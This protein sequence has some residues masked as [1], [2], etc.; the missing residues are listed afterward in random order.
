MNAKL[1]STIILL[2]TSGLSLGE[3]KVEPKKPAYKVSQLE[4]A[5]QK[6]FIFLKNQKKLLDERLKRQGAQ[7]SQALQKVQEKIARLQT[8]QI[9]LSAELE[10]GD[11][12]LSLL[13][14]ELTDHTEQKDM[15]ENTLL[16]SHASLAKLGFETDANGSVGLVQQMSSQFQTGMQAL[17]QWNSLRQDKGSFFLSDGTKTDGSFIH[18]GSIA[19]FG[20]SA[21]E[22]GALVPVGDGSFKIWKKADGTTMPIPSKQDSKLTSV[23][24]FGSTDKAITNKK[25]KKLMDTLN[26][27]GLIGFVITGLGFVAFL[28]IAIKGVLLRKAQKTHSKVERDIEDHLRERDFSAAKE[29]CRQQHG[30]TPRLAQ[31]ALEN[32]GNPKFEDIVSES[33][34]NQSSK[35]D[36]FGSFITVVAAVAPLLGLL[37]TVTGMIATFDIITEAGT[38]DPKLLSGGISEALVTTMFGLIVAI[39]ALLMGNMLTSWAESLKSEMEKIVLK[40]SNAYHQV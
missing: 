14:K 34:I 39:P 28:T 11:K 25:P 32:L 17:Q 12:K 33:F 18:V 27:G 40:I 6:E 36:L 23:F 24:L 31:T 16:Q 10:R 19:A 13:D 7:H 2:V 35:L 29:A 38:G 22:S 26:A 8:Q 37:G 15:I 5:Y 4:E 30:L 3:A 9:Q 20:T 21:K 1:T